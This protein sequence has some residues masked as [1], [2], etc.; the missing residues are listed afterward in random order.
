M[1]DWLQFGQ[2]HNNNIC[3]EFNNEYVFIDVL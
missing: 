2:L 1:K 3:G